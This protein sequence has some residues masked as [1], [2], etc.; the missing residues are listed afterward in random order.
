MHDHA[1]GTVVRPWT[2]SLG[3]RGEMHHM[4]LGMSRRST[5]CPSATPRRA[6]FP[7][8]SGHHVL[9]LQGRCLQAFPTRYTMLMADA[10]CTR[11]RPCNCDT[12]PVL[13]RHP[14]PAA[15]VFPASS[16]TAA[17]PFP[18]GVSVQPKNSV[19][20]KLK[21]KAVSRDTR[22]VSW[23]NGRINHRPLFTAGEQSN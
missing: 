10:A 16:L 2:S 14:V 3:G 15:S 7:G 19:H 12:L 22:C 18:G 17:S 6:S 13:I 23:R 5:K 20:R 4:N 21:L 11:R 1:G 9:A 8:R